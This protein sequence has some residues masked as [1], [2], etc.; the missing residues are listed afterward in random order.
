MRLTIV[1][2][3]QRNRQQQFCRMALGILSIVVRQYLHFNIFLRSSHDS[4]RD[5]TISVCKGDVP[6][7]GQ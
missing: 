1:P 6:L 3:V 2:V 7:A 4:L 5:V